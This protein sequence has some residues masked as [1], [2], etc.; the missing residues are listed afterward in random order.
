MSGDQ[1]LFKKHVIE[2]HHDI[3]IRVD[4]RGTLWCVEVSRMS[5]FFF[6]LDYIYIFCFLV[7]DEIS[8]LKK[9]KMLSLE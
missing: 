1:I 8:H 5:F 4:D 3:I 7:I 9:I 6:L 2:Y